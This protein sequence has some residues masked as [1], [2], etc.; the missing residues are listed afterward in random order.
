MAQRQRQHHRRKRSTV[1]LQLR[2]RLC[3]L[4]GFGG[5]A[6]ASS[7]SS[8]FDNDNDNNNQQYN[9]S[10]NN[11]HIWSSPSTPF[12]TPF[13]SGHHERNHILTSNLGSHNLP[14]IHPTSNNNN[15][16]NH[17]LTSSNNHSLSSSNTPSTPTSSLALLASPPARALFDAAVVCAWA[18]IRHPNMVFAAGAREGLRDAVGLFCGDSLLFGGG[19]SLHSTPHSTPQVSSCSFYSPWSGR[20]EAVRVLEG[21]ARRA[22]GGSVFAC[23]VNC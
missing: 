9:H 16:H 18:A 22:G 17:N 19:S 8:S 23:A 12:P 11:G 1:R 7:S 15:N 5:D 10:Q 20:K 14:S 2:M 4:V 13:S 3:R 21:L 6:L